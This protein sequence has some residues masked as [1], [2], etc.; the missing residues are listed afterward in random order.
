M[1]KYTYIVH[2]ERKYKRCNE[3]DLS[4]L[5][6]SDAS[7][8]SFYGTISIDNSNIG[9]ENFTGEHGAKDF[10]QDYGI[11]ITFNEN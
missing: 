11:E 4:G 3:I 6:N 5:T 8:K 2:D 1:S 7:K 10:M 9:W